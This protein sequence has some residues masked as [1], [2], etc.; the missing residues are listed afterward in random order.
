MAFL[1]KGFYLKLQTELDQLEERCLT[2]EGAAAAA[3][4]RVD[5]QERWAKRQVSDNRALAF[6]AQAGQA[7]AEAG[8][9]AAEQEAERL[10]RELAWTRYQLTQQPQ[11]TELPRD[12][13][14]PAS[15]PQVNQVQPAGTRKGR[16]QQRN[17]DRRADQKER[18]RAARLER[19]ADAALAQMAALEE[20]AEAALPEETEADLAEEGAAAWAEE[21]EADLAQQGAAAWA[22]SAD[23]EGG[24]S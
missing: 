10:R 7:A 18:K 24:I 11:S 20:E 6:S 13:L 9:A 12:D 21:T 23:V 14:L 16:E 22:R 1:H 15:Q 4:R 19:R 17:K 3:K 5:E 2:A 8:Q